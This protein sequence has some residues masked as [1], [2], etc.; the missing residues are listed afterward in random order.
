MGHTSDHREAFSVSLAALQAEIAASEARGAA[1]PA[2]AHEMVER[3]REVVAALDG[4]TASI[5]QGERGLGRVD[6]AQYT[7]QAR[8]DARVDEAAEESFPA[9]DPPSWE[10]LH[11]GAPGEGRDAAR[12]EDRAT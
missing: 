11:P 10:P 12:G 1:V 7:E 3:L 2:E 8:A 4:L 6:A 5:G 9:S